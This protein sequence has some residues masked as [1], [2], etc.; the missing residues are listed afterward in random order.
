ME[1]YLEEDPIGLSKIPFVK[2]ITLVITFLILT[3]L[4]LATSLFSLY[5]L[6]GSVKDTPQ[7]V[8]AAETSAEVMT[9]VHI[10]ASLPAVS[11]TVETEVEVA[12]ARVELIRKYLKRYDSPLLPYADFV[13]SMADHYG[14]DF[15]LTTAI[16]QQES[17][18]CKKIPADTHNC[19]GWGIHS[20][21]TLG[22]SSLKEGIEVVSR[23]LKDGY[24][25]YGYTTP[26][27]I[28][29]KYTPQSNGSWSS[30][31]SQF[32]DDMR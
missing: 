16:A 2:G 1:P 28:M 3:P 29:T 23:G 20:E 31:V 17:N 12:D 5:V 9:G 18:L 11:P 14:L 4:T 6:S 24:I 15:R 19:W 21:G 25:D 13:V 7:N 8:L 22:F 27:A 10:F 30:G 26:E 32:M